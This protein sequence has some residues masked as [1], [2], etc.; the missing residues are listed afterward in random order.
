M[1]PCTKPNCNC[2]EQAEK[3]AGGPVKNYPCLADMPE[4][5]PEKTQLGNEQEAAK[6]YADYEVG[7]YDPNDPNEAI[8][9]EETEIAWKYEHKKCT[10]AFLAGAKWKEGQPQIQGK[11]FF[12]VLEENYQAQIAGY[13]NVDKTDE[14][15]KIRNA[16]IK[17][18]QDLISIYKSNYNPKD[19]PAATASKAQ[20]DEKGMSWIYKEIKSISEC[21]FNSRVQLEGS[22]G[23]ESWWQ[24]ELKMNDWLRNLESADKGQTQLE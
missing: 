20:G 23:F 21:A 9:N 18:Y 13:Y 11:D 24:D 10:D 6:E 2:I 17:E 15:R 14:E 7:V 1:K 16:V 19:F 8:V 4:A 3:E 5:H 12:P 22:Q